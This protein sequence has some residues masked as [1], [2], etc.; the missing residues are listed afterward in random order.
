VTFSEGVEGTLFG[1]RNP[2]IVSA[3]NS[4]VFVGDFE[5]EGSN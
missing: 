1:I 5:G 3:S 4:F 2:L